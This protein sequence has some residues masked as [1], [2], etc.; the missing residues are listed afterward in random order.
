MR[1]LS[2]KESKM[3]PECASHEGR[4]TRAQSQRTVE[5]R[6]VES[7]DVAQTQRSSSATQSG[8]SLNG[9]SISTIIHPSHETAAT[10]SEDENLENTSGFFVSLA[11]PPDMIMGACRDLHVSLAAL[12]KLI[13]AFHSNMTAFS[14]FHLPTFGLKTQNVTSPSI[15]KA[16]FAAMLAFGARFETPPPERVDEGSLG[17]ILVGTPSHEKFHSLSLQFLD[18][19]IDECGDEPPSLCLL[20]VAI[21]TTFYQLIQGV[22]G[23]AWRSLGLCVR[24]A[25]E[26]GLHQVDSG[27]PYRQAPE[28]TDSVTRWCFD[29]E[30]RRAWWAIWEMDSF[31]STIRRCPTAIDWTE[32]ETSATWNAS[33]SNG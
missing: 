5:Q 13:D 29:E 26:L 16:G 24:M 10:S 30:R 14:L 27:E 21:L 3:S 6:T 31:A 4:D 28:S 9:V 20:Q 22:R 32:N 18:A 8:G 15:L 2:Q 1:D 11:G 33:L 19:A 23:R 7:P 25:Y 12:R 17:G